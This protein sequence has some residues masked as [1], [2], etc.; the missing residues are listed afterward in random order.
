MYFLLSYINTV[1]KREKGSA[2]I[3]RQGQTK[4]PER[5]PSGL[6]WFVMNVNSSLI[7]DSPP[8]SPMSNRGT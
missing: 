1:V 7:L 8:A 3:L 4:R 6:R 2:D 5:L